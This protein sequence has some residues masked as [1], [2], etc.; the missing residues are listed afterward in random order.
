MDTIPTVIHT[1][2]GAQNSGG[3]ISNDAFIAGNNY[4]LF[5][6]SSSPGVK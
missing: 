5:H 2:Q 3:R 4:F 6:K 1:L